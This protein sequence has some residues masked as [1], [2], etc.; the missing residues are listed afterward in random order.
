[1]IY[2]NNVSRR[3]DRLV[4][5]RRLIIEIAAVTYPDHRHR[6]SR[7]IYFVANAPVAY[8]NAP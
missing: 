4:E 5:P 2:R 3:P 6:P 8:A 7:I 1:M